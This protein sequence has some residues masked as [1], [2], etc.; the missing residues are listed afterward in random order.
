MARLKTD[1]AALRDALLK[2]QNLNEGLGVDKMDLN[3][4]VQQVGTRH[5]GTGSLLEST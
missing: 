5:R 4:M 2:I 1:E 3:Q